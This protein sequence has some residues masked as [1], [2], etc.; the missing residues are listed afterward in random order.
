[1]QRFPESETEFPGRENVVKRCILAVIRCIATEGSDAEDDSELA[2][3]HSFEMSDRVFGAI[4][5][6]TRERYFG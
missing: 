3:A 1:M 6:K 4:A 5:E 2:R